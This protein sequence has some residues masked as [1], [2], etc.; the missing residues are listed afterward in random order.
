MNHQIASFTTGPTFITG[1]DY[2]YVNPGLRPDC[3]V[4]AILSGAE[5]KRNVMGLAFLARGLREQAA[6]EFRLALQLAPGNAEARHNLARL[7]GATS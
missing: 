3:Q 6:A 4:I 1:H 7:Y 5:H 2:V